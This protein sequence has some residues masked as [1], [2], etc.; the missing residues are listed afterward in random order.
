METMAVYGGGRGLGGWAGN[1]SF[2]ALTETTS[3]NHVSTYG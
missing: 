1:L 2:D 3:P